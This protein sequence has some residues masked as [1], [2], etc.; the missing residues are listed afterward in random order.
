MKKNWI[1]ET[2]RRLRPKPM[3]HETHY[4]CNARLKAEGGKAKCCSCKPHEGCDMTQPKEHERLENLICEINAMIESGSI[5][6]GALGLSEDSVKF[7]REFTTWETLDG[8]PRQ[9]MVV[10]HPPLVDDS[11]EKVSLCNS[12]NTMSHT[13][14]GKCGK[15]GATPPKDN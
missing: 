1:L 11:L 12:C 9:P 13:I 7:C 2:E 6:T 3:T 10:A 8:I 15:H 4:C 5:I 14:K